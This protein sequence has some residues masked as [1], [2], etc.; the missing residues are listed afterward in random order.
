MANF[1]EIAR[2]AREKSDGIVD[3]VERE[4]QAREEAERVRLQKAFRVLHD[5]VVPILEEARDAFLKDGV[6]VD[7][8]EAESYRIVTGSRGESNKVRIVTFECFSRDDQGQSGSK[9]I[10]GA[11]FVF[12]SDGSTIVAKP[13]GSITGGQTFPGGTFPDFVAPVAAQA[14]A[15]YYDALRGSRDRKR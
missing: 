9:I 10:K 15:S 5:N 3:A 6:K 8:N 7:I 13:Y 4:K 11:K 1:D 12:E 14:L 2:A